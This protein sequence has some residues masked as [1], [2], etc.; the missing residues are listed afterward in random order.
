MTIYRDQLTLLRDEGDGYRVNGR[1]VA[2][3]P[4]S[5]PIECNIQPVA[6]SNESQVL[7][8][9]IRAY[10]AEMVFTKTLI[11]GVD[12]YGEK[13]ADKTTIDDQLY[14]AESVKNYNR[15]GSS[16]IGHFAALFVRQDKLKAGTRP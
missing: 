14:I 15:R 5:I 6:D 1:W 3:S 12:Q 11:K 9:G 10:D 16:T 8:E 7:P 2:G 13:L 4:T